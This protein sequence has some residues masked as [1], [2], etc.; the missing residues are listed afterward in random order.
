MHRKYE[1]VFF[2]HVSISLNDFR[3]HASKIVFPCL[4]SRDDGFILLQLLLYTIW[5]TISS[6][7]SD[8]CVDIA[9]TTVLFLFIFIRS[10]ECKKCYIC[11]KASVPSKPW[12]ICPHAS[13]S[14]SSRRGRG[15]IHDV[16]ERLRTLN[17]LPKALH[18][19]CGF[20]CGNE[21]GGI[22]ANGTVLPDPCPLCRI[23]IEVR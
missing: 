4:A 12:Y 2:S 3:I 16:T 21:D 10:I 14:R 13:P 11:D 23:Q 17:E 1:I 6:H 9:L 18:V 19:V 5:V 7:S 8:F 20:C 22:G 15:N